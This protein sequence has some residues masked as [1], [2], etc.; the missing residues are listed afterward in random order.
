[1]HC[2]THGEHP[3]FCLPG[4]FCNVASTFSRYFQ[5]HTSVLDSPSTRLQ[6]PAVCC[7]SPAESLSSQCRAVRLKV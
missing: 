2:C 3:N 1:M 7:A 4:C 5:T 6:Q